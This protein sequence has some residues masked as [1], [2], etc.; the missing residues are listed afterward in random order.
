KLAK[1]L[2]VFVFVC[3]TWIFFR[4]ESLPDALFISGRIFKAAW[5][6]P[7]VPILMLLLVLAVWLYQ[8]TYESRLREVLRSNFGRVDIAVAMVVYIALCSSGAGA[9]IYFQF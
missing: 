1:Q 6:D 5:T 4:A 9:F 8:F 2:G 3:F 7:G